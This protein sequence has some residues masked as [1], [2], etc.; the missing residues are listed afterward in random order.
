MINLPVFLPCGFTICKKCESNLDKSLKNKL[1]KCFK[2]PINNCNKD[3]NKSNNFPVND[4]VLKLITFKDQNEN[5][6]HLT[7]IDDNQVCIQN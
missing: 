4:L 2:C 7:N 1:I 3:H 5:Q 6:V